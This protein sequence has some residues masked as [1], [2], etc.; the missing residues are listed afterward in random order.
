MSDEMK[1]RERE[2]ERDAWIPR[3]WDDDWHFK[4]DEYVSGFRE[5]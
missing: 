3:R 4:V 5:R 2:R 1:R